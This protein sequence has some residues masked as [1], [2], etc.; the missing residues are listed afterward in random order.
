MPCSICFIR[1]LRSI[2][3]RT[4]KCT[5]LTDVYRTIFPICTEVK[6]IVQNNSNSNCKLI[7]P[8]MH[9]SDQKTNKMGPDAL[10]MRKSLEPITI[11]THLRDILA[12]SLLFPLKALC[13]PLGAGGIRNVLHGLLS[14]VLPQSP[15]FSTGGW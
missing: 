1:N 14:P 7:T 6:Y 9:S 3:S 15:V 8:I 12:S 11:Q 5:Y 13:S 2:V 4:N 10:Q